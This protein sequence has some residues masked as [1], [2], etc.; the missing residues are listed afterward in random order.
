MASIF[1]IAV[2][3]LS[4]ATLGMTTAAT[5]SAQKFFLALFLQYVGR[6]AQVNIYSP[7]MSS[8]DFTRLRV[9]NG[10]SLKSDVRSLHNFPMNVGVRN[11]FG[12]RR[13]IHI[14]AKY[15]RDTGVKQWIIQ[16]VTNLVIAQ[17]AP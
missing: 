4:V 9:Q 7:N 3:T 17:A 11:V 13:R 10:D 5:A 14:F 2:L 6:D 12:H 1:L 16:V 8:E 15:G